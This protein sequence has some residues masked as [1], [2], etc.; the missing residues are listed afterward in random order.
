MKLNFDKTGAVPKAVGSSIVFW[1]Y[2]NKS[3]LIEVD[4][5]YYAV[6]YYNGDSIYLR[7]TNDDYRVIK[8]I[9]A[10]GLR[11]TFEE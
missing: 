1:D 3:Y 4:G 7:H 2:P 5:Y 11:L 10:D 6:V 9:T 8:I